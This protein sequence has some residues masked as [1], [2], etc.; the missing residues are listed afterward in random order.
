MEETL[1][2]VWHFIAFY[3]LVPLITAKL[4]MKWPSTAAYLED[5]GSTPSMV[6]AMER[7]SLLCG[8]VEVKFAKDH[9]GPETLFL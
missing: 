1:P 5:A 3:V 2:G 4:A 9:S 6:D 7:S 8:V